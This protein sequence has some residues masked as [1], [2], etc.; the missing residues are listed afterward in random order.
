MKY[1]RV[2]APQGVSIRLGRSLL[3]WVLLG[4]LSREAQQNDQ[5]E[6]ERF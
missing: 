5:V 2:R 3:D 1:G 4:L 6:S